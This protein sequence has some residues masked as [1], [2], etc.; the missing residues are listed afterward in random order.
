MLLFSDTVILIRKL[1]LKLWNVQSANELKTINI[2][3][4]FKNG[5]GYHDEV[6]VLVK[7]CSWSS[8]GTAIVVAAKNKLFVSI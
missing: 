7:C 2:G 3:D 8:N 6:E 4:F 5:E 1:F